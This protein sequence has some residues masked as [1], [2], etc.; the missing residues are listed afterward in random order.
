[1][2][3]GLLQLSTPSVAATGDFIGTLKAAL[4]QM[5]YG[6]DMRLFLLVP[7]HL[8]AELMLAR[9]SG[10]WIVSGGKIGDAITMVCSDALTSSDAVLL[11][12]SQI[13][14]SSDTFEFKNS[15]A[16]ALALADTAQAPGH[17]VSLFQNDL[18]AAKSERYFGLEITRDSSLCLITNITTA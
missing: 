4:A 6:A 16:S 18:V 17:L 15:T 11:D 7:P 5:T 2:D 3:A 9:D 12:A 8:N 1:V 10:G 14:V 13:A